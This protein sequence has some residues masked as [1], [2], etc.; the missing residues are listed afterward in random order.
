MNNYRDEE[1]RSLFRD[2]GFDCLREDS[3]EDQRL[4]LFSQRA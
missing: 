4:Y 1:I 3:W 2:R